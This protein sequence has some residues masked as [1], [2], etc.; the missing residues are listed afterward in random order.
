MDLLYFVALVAACA[1]H[2]DLATAKALVA[3]ESSFN[4]HAIGVVA[5]SLQRQPRNRGEGV[6][7]ARRLQAD[8]WNFSVGLAQINVRNFERL[9][10]TNESAFDPCANLAAMQ[11]VLTDCYDRAKRQVDSPQRSLRQALS[12]YYSGNFR[13]GFDH[14]YVQRVVRSAAPLSSVQPQESP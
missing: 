10:L 5:G 11:V 12:C 6:A 8:G 13:T 7:T 2:V 1:P 9:G 14:G 3:T 4:P